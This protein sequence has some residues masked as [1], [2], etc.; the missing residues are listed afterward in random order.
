LGLAGLGSF[1]VPLIN[2]HLQQI[3]RCF[4]IRLRQHFDS[5]KID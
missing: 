3:K 1:Y 5:V 4:L 2:P